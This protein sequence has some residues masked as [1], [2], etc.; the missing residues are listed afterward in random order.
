MACRNEMTFGVG[1]ILTNPKNQ[2][3][4][5]KSAARGRIR[6]AFRGIDVDWEKYNTKDYLFTHCTAVCS[7]ETED[8]GYWIK[9]ACEEL[10]N[11]NG[12]AWTN[13]VLMNSFKTFIGAENYLEHRQDPVLSK[14]KILD[15]ILRPVKHHSEKYNQDANVYF[16]DILV[17]TARIHEDLVERIESGELTGLSMGCVA[18]VVTC[19]ICGKQIK[20]DDR[21][22]EHLSRHLGKMVEC[23][24]GK[25]RICAELCGA[26][27]EKGE[28]VP[29]SVVF[30]EES[31]VQN[32]ACQFCLINSF[33]ETEEERKFRIEKK[34]ELQKLFDGNLFERLRV[35]DK[36]SKIAL[37][38]VKESVHI[39]RLA[40]R[41]LD[42]I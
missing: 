11:A 34:D 35:A 3:E 36:E 22:C 30:I 15:A 28:Y 5:I 9:P 14:G 37:K 26:V 42:E 25:E 39:D 19:S 10:V 38:I 32:P 1:R 21:D 7:V 27:D 17:A 8:N 31:W 4:D 41:L 24:D 16:C 33:V 23:S 6:I 2:W 18:N 29:D 20:D 13:V 12:N 40:K